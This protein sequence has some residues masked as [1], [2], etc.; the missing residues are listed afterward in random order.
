MSSTR[1]VAL[2]RGVNVGG[3]T[4]INAALAETFV[5]VGFENISTVL[6]SGNVAFDAAGNASEPND[7]R[8]KIEAALRRDFHYDAWIVLRTQEQLAQVAFDYPFVRTDDTDHP[9]LV[10]SSSQDVA[11]EIL[12][13]G[14]NILS[15]AE[16]L[17]AGAGVLYWRVPKGASLDTPFAKLLA[18]AHYKPHLTTRN[19]RTVEKLVNA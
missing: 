9:Y 17:Q 6:A 18:R 4:I 10:F 8:A 1:Y 12:K 19:L 2:L 16:A 14:T 15:T 3:V 5:K 11:D 7:I 13:E